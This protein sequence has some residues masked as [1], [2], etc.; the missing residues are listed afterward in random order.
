MEFDSLGARI[1]PKEEKA[2]AC[3]YKG[4][5]IYPDDLIIEM[6]NGDLVF[7]GDLKTYIEELDENELLEMI[8]V[9]EVR[10][11]SNLL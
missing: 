5:E 4:E 2:V 1:E 11:C 3:D 10:A 6:P 7:S 9:R 8:D